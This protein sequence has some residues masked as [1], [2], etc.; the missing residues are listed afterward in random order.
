[1][2]RRDFLKT[3]I[4]AAA[5]PA[6]VKADNI[7]KIWVPPEKRIINYPE[8]YVDGIRNDTPALQALFDGGK[9]IYEGNIISGY[10]FLAKISN[11]PYR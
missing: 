9:V 7:M 3:M 11:R 2:N 6:I 1:M 4:A 8:L 5:A 10:N